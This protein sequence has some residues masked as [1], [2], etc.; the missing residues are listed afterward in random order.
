M[1]K[2]DCFYLLFPLDIFSKVIDTF[3]QS[4]QKGGLIQ[5]Y[6]RDVGT[7]KTFGFVI[8]AERKCKI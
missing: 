6:D 4:N 5:Q 8:S 7:P 1:S 2:Y 3:L